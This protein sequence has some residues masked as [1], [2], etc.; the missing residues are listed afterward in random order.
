MVEFN[1]IPRRELE[2][3]RDAD[4]PM[5]E[6]L[7]LYAD[8]CRA[9]TLLAIKKAG[10]GHIGSSFSAMDIVVHL[11]LQ[12]MNTLKVGVESPDRDIYFSSKGHDVPGLY[13]ALYGF[14]VISEEQLLQL[15]RL[16]GLDGHPDIN[17]SGVEANSGSLGMGI[18]KARGMAFGKRQKGHGGH[19]YVLLGDGE[20][21]EGQI[22]E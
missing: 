17:I 10:S 15:R 16:G 11:Y 7:S 22:Y 13:A 5:P 14:G 1:L 20:L 4:I 18:G 3:L 6:K 21:Q 2:R 12:T 8:C 19:V 9:N